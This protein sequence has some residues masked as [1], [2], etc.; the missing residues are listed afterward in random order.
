MEIS[1]SKGKKYLFIT[2]KGRLD[3]T[4]S[5]ELES[6]VKDTVFPYENNIL[7]DFSQLDY[8]SS[9]GLRTIL[10][11]SK[12]LKEKGHTF[13]ICCVQDHILE[14]FEISGFDSFI[15]IFTSRDDYSL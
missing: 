14:V 1:L 8:V 2:A 3:T 6:W 10:N 15:P 4:G 12:G 9:A 11:L 13:A 7:M 5:A